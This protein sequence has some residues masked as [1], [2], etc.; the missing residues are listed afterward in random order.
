MSS[1]TYLKKRNTGKRY[2]KVLLGPKLSCRLTGMRD[3]KKRLLGAYGFGEEKAGIYF[4]PYSNRR[5]FEIAPEERRLAVRVSHFVSQLYAD[6]QNVRY[7]VEIDGHGE[8]AYSE[9]MLVPDRPA[10]GQRGQRALP[11]EV[12]TSYC[13]KI[14]DG[15]TFSIWNP[16]R[17]LT[18][19]S[20]I[21]FLEEAM[22]FFKLQKS[23]AE[24]EDKQNWISFSRPFAVGTTLN[25]WMGIWTDTN[26]KTS[27]GIIE[28]NSQ[29]INLY[30][31]ATTVADLCCIS[32]ESKSGSGIEDVIGALERNSDGLEALKLLFERERFQG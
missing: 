5:V 18:V 27:Q 28:L 1:T 15:V 32:P 8:L 20:A 21:S 10:S 2:S 16:A 29:V 24:S 31:C 9:T 11:I 23:N 25:G 30:S 14:L 22:E 4:M 12:G 6:K 7:V 13:I 19:Q 26:R 3:D 17:K